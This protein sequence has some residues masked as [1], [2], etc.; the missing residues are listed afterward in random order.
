MVKQAIYALYK[1]DQFMDIGTATELAEKLNCKVK[2]I[3]QY[4]MPTKRECKNT[5]LAIRIE[6]DTEGI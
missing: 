1:G 5:L 6:D 3:Y 4:A 2:T